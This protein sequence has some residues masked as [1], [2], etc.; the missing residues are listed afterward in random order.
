MLSYPDGQAWR[1]VGPLP[2]PRSGL[3]GASLAGV[4]HVTGGFNGKHSHNFTFTNNPGASTPRY[5]DSVLAWDPVTETWSEAAKLAE[6]RYRHAVT[7]L[8]LAAVAHYC[9]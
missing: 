2:L 6:A 8:P 9:N 5:L 3:R 7:E 4:L 1:E